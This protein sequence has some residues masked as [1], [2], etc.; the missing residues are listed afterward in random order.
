MRERKGKCGKS[1]IQKIRRSAVS[2]AGKLLFWVRQNLSSLM[3]KIL[4][5]EKDFHKFFHIMWKTVR[6][7]V[8]IV[9]LLISRR[10]SSISDE[11]AESV[12]ICFS[13]A[14][15]LENTVE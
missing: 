15:M 3:R 7:D 2:D 14:E 11:R 6:K 5:S 13:T 12:F 9:Y 1:K 8:D 4:P 10:I